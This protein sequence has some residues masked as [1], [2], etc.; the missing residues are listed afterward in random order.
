MSDLLSVTDLHVSYRVGAVHAVRGVDLTVAEGECLA[1]VGESGSG[2]SAIAK[3][4]LGLTG[5]GST[6]RAADLTVAGIDLTR[7]SERRWRTIRGA[8]VA[9]IPQDP[10]TALDPL[11]RVGAEITETLRNHRVVPRSQEHARVIDLLTEVRMPD[12]DLRARQ[13]P[14]QLSGG[15]R[16][17][18]LIA[19]AVAAAPHLLIADE[20]TT[21]LD[22]TLQ[23]RILDLLAA[24]KAIGV[25]VLLISHDL[26]AVAHLADRVAVM[27]AGEIVET[28]PTTAVLTAPEHPYTKQLLAAV[29]SA[30]TRG[31]RL[32]P[33]PARTRPPHPQPANPPS[34]DP[35]HPDNLAAGGR[36]PST[37]IVSARGVHKSFRGPDGVVRP[38]VVD[39]SFD[40][41]P[42]EVLG[43]VGESGS[44]KSTV[45]HL[46]LGLLEPDAGEVAVFGR[47][48]AEA[49]G[50]VQWVQQDPLGSFD[51]RYTVAR[52]IAE[53]GV[54]TRRVL[55][56]L[57][58]V[59]LE[60]ALADRDPRTLSGGQRQRVAIARALAP[61]PRA[62]VCDEPVSALDVS[63]QAQI[64]DLFADL[65]AE[66]G[67]SLV[68]ISHDLGVIAHASDRVLVMKDGRVVESGPVTEVFGAPEHPY[69]RELLSVP[70]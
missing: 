18:A 24:R 52:V 6:V 21:A 70:A 43:I 16:Q 40:L 66:L 42:D 51:P 55:E 32:S 22:S 7:L 9:L 2:K 39:V 69:T 65:R 67:T 57:D 63:V 62:V 19:S 31:T 61:E 64:L 10:L 12:P 50:R 11:R 17:R 54:D 68:L 3:A 58:L 1:V 49:R 48:P 44:G 38:A 53:A 20:P 33:T 14:H 56:L 41:A 37:P 60:R 5:P 59:G 36:T 45:A 4:L 23:T 15:L 46:L 26:T 35:H 34:P 30:R 47:P 27:R 25:G 29:P 8:R 28:G 13:H